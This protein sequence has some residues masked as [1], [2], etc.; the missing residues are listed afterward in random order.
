MKIGLVR[1]FEVERG[2]PNKLLTSDELL[3][4]VGEYDA[5]AVIENDVH[6]RGIDWKRCFASDLTR[7]EYTARKVFGDNV[8]LLEELR[9]IR[10]SPL[11]RAK[12]KLPLFV[13]LLFIRLAWYFNHPSQPESRTAVVERIRR[14]LENILDSEEDVLIVSHGG[15]MMFMR[16]ELMKLGF[17]GPKFGKPKNGEVYVFER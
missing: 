3:K 12:M 1:H 7:A 5:S 14:S 15:I 8:V 4:W 11:F 2:Y 13:H 6:M 10:L 16:K 9:E 17:T